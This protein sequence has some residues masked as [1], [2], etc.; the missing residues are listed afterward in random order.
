MPRSFEL[1]VQ[2]GGKVVTKKLKDGKYMRLC[3]TPRGRWV[4]GEVR[5]KGDTALALAAYARKRR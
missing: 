2:H 3:K 4:T 5:K 1:C